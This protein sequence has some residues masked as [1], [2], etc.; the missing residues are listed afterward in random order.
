MGRSL[1][2]GDLKAAEAFDNVQ[3]AMQRAASDEMTKLERLVPFLA[4]T[5]S[6]E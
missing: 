5:G 4:T 2:R 1:E 6:S 3:R